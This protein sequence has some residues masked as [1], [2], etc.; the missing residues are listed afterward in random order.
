MKTV[1]GGAYIPVADLRLPGFRG[2]ASGRFS[3][4][5]I[6]GLHSLPSG[7]GTPVSGR[8][9]PA[10]RPERD[11]AGIP[12]NIIDGDN[13]RYVRDTRAYPFSTICALDILNPANRRFH[14][15]GVL[16]GKQL[17]LTA[18]HNVFFHSDGGWM[19]SVM[20]YPGLNGN[21]QASPF[22]RAQATSF[23]SLEAWTKNANE[24]FDLGAILLPTPLG[25]LAGWLAVAKLTTNT[26]SNLVVSLTG[27]PVECPRD[28]FPDDTSTM[29]LDT[30]NVV[31]ETNRLTYQM[32]ST[33]GQSGAPLMAHFPQKTSDEYQVVGIHNR[34]FDHENAATRINDALFDRIIEWLNISEA[35][36]PG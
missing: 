1:I 26:L 31:C 21:R 18:G 22:G 17:V 29:W 36:K 35:R 14:G 27:Y 9:R 28:E 16:I 3:R 13:R 20:V 25:E 7:Y 4:E 30:G 23:L 15:T 8:A 2:A 10:R 5:T 24:Q 6:E 33:V 34:A 12:E 11:G 32:D 19:A